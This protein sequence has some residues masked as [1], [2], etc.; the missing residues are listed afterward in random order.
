MHVLCVVGDAFG[1]WIAS[2]LSQTPMSSH[3]QSLKYVSND[4]LIHGESSGR[5]VEY[6]Q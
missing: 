6:I 5:V 4:G 3:L 2:R 1:R